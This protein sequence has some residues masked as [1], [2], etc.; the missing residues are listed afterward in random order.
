M[1]KY[2]YCLVITII[3]IS[4]LISCSNEKQNNIKFENNKLENITDREILNFLEEVKNLEKSIYYSFNIEKS[5]I[6]KLRVLM[7]LQKSVKV[8]IKSII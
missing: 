3:V 6:V 5:K 7:K 8:R 2:I 1:K 4:S